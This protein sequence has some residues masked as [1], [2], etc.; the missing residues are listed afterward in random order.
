MKQKLPKGFMKVVSS[1]EAG[2]SEI[3]QSELVASCFENTMELFI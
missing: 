3:C 1:C 2:E